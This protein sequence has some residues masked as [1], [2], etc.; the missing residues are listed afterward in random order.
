M[1]RCVFFS[2]NDR[3]TAF[4][5]SGHV[6][7]GIKGKDVVCAA[8]SA[9]TQATI[10]GLKEVLGEKIVYEIKDGL[11]KCD[12]KSENDCAQKMIET[13]QKTLLQ[14]SKQYP[15]NLLVFQTEV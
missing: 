1:T 2:H 8:V 15:K 9:V 3:Y 10:I 6:G 14:L 7:L 4:K 5:I 11:I 13:L 12:A